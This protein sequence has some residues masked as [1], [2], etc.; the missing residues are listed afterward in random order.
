MLKDAANASLVLAV[1]LPGDAKG[2]ADRV[3]GG[4]AE[5]DVAL[6]GAP[7]PIAVHSDDVQGSARR[8]AAVAVVLAIAAVA[9]AVLALVRR[10]PHGHRRNDGRTAAAPMARPLPRPAA[11][12][13][14]SRPRP[15]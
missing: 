14:R 1:E 6:G 4:R 5:W 10:S 11:A 13:A 12:P 9:A 2:S 15:R 8:W 3:D 7:T